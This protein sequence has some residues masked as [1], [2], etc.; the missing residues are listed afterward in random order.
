MAG[1]GNSNVRKIYCE[2]CD[3]VL[4]SRKEFDKH[5]ESHGRVCGEECPL[6]TIASKI[7]R[8][9]RRDCS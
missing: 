8:L 3:L 4:N 1:L 7:S 2:K 9:F 5:L 6:D